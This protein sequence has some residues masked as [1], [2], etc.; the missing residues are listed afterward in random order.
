MSRKFVKIT[1]KSFR[2]D[3]ATKIGSI[4]FLIMPMQSLSWKYI[5]FPTFTHL[6]VEKCDCGVA[7]AF[8]EPLKA[9]I[10]LS[11]E[12]EPLKRQI[13]HFS[14]CQ[15]SKPWS[16]LRLKFTLKKENKVP[17]KRKSTVGIRRL[18]LMLWYVALCCSMLRNSAICYYLQW[19]AVI[20]CDTLWYALIW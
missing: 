20:C 11:A 7:A 14:T 5:W 8:E 3:H 19:Y 9:S 15:S 6:S 10:S 13:D 17:Q 4:L 16:K 2:M 18:N 1:F 12:S